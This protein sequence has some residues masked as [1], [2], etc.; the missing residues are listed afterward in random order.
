M[1]ILVHALACWTLLEE[2]TE[3][4]K[5]IQILGCSKEINMNKIN[6]NKINRDERTRLD[7]NGVRLM[8]YYWNMII[9]IIISLR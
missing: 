6:M 3:I 4:L 7:N 9:R 1:K 5:L 8:D 2:E